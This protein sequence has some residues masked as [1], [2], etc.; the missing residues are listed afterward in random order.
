MVRMHSKGRVLSRRVP[1]DAV[2]RFSNYLPVD[3]GWSDVYGH[4]VKS[5][6]PQEGAQS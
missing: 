5:F 2:T 6:G 3:H 4:G 1:V